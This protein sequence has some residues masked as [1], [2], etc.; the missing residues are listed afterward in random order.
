MNQRSSQG[1]LR[2]FHNLPGTTPGTLHINPSAASTQIELI[3]YNADTAMRLPLANPHDCA[4]YFDTASIS[5]VD[6]RG[7]GSEDTFQALKDVFNLHPLVLEDLVNV[8]QRP[9]VENYGNQLVIV[10]HM[11]TYLPQ[12]KRLVQEQISFVVGQ[13]Y[14][15]T[16]QEE[17]ENDCFEPVRHRIQ[18]N[19]G[20][21]RCMGVDYLTYAL[22]DAIVDGFFPALE[23][24]GDRLDDLEDRVVARPNEQALHQIYDLKRDLA[25][26]RHTVWLQR[27]TLA[28]LL[29]D[30][31]KFIGEEIDIYLRDCYDHGVQLLEIVESY[32]DRSSALVDIYLSVMSNRMN[33][34]MKTLTVISTIFMPLT[35][36]AG[37]YGMNFNPAASPYNMPELNWYWGYVAVWIAMGAIAASLIVFFW[38]RG[39]FRNLSK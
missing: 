24:Y 36:I 29:R 34:V 26:L 30:N 15:L 25:N 13:H 22:L 5:W 16:V 27:E 32:R 6:V 11:V 39:W 19:R 38:R 8:P 3:D 4:A 33:D 23:A 10:T 18:Q 28:S 21:I 31:D 7:L 17:I 9:K 35:F 37:I 1:R 14:L 20:V 12:E 2:Y